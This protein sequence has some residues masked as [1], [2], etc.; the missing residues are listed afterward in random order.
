MK[1]LRNAFVLTIIYLLISNLGNIFF[2]V[3]ERFSW[4]TTLWEGVFFFIFV[5]LIQS[6][7]K[8]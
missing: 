1:K 5:F 7:R 4:T 2:G 8:K 3:S 6:Y